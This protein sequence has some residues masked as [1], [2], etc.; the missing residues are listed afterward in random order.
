MTATDTAKQLTGVFV[1]DT[2]KVGQVVAVGGIDYKITEINL[3][4][5]NYPVLTKVS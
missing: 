3:A 5:P 4:R 1:A 2:V